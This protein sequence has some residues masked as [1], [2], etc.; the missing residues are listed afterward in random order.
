MTTHYPDVFFSEY[1][2]VRHLHLGTEDWIQGSMRINK[3]FEIELEYV[4]RMM[5][6]LL[7]FPPQ[8]ISNLHAMQLGLGAATITKFCHSTLVMNTTAVELNPQVVNI[9]HAWFNLPQPDSKLNI[10]IADAQDV[11][12]NNEL[13]GTVDV[14]CVDIYDDEASAPVI[15]TV[16]LYSRCKKILT[17]HGIMTVNLFGRN[18]TFSESLQNIAKGF[19][20]VIND[21][22]N[23]ILQFPPTVEG[24]TIVLAMT[25]PLSTPRTELQKR[26][27]LIEEQWKLPATQWLKELHRPEPVK[28]KK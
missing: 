24:N 13:N 10:I 2:G 15:D 4:R 28:T 16:E 25:Q 22:Q 1:K 14:L 26:A 27:L 18:S 7:F 12:N 20:T 6:W 23:T 17:P 21:K 8:H 19:G 3:P 5:A 11:I 9:C